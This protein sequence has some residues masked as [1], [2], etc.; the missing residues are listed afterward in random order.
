MLLGNKDWYGLLGNKGVFFWVLG[1]VGRDERGVPGAV[2]LSPKH[3][4]GGLDAVSGWPAS[5]FELGTVLRRKSLKAHSLPMD[6]LLLLL[7]DAE[8][9]DFFVWMS[10]P[11]DARLDSW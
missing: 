11:A 7:P 6:G 8:A 10:G 4:L 5:Y 1:E 9:D 2:L 3:L